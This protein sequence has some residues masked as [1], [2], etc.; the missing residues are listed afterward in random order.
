MSRFFLLFSF[1]LALLLGKADFLL[2]QTSTHRY[3][4]TAHS[5]FSEQVVLIGKAFDA[6]VEITNQGTEPVHSIGYTYEFAGKSSSEWVYRLPFPLSYKGETTRLSLPI[7]AMKKSGSGRLT[8]RIKSVNDQKNEADLSQA[9]AS[10][11]LAVISQSAKRKIVVEDFT[12]T[13]C[14]YCPVAIGAMEIL[15]RDFKDRVIPL[16]VHVHRDVMRS[17][18]YSSVVGTYV[19]GF[20]SVRVNRYKDSYVRLGEDYK[21]GTPYGLLLDIEAEEKV[22]TEAAIKI[23]KATYDPES[24]RVNIET[25]TTFGMSGTDSPYRLAYVLTADGLTGNSYY[26][27]QL[28]NYSG[29]KYYEHLIP[30][31]FKAASRVAIKFDH[32]VV[33]A[34]DVLRGDEATLPANYQEGIAYSHKHA[35]DVSRTESY[36]ISNEHI[37]Q[38]KNKLTAVVMLINTRTRR[39]VNADSAPVVLSTK[40][41]SVRLELGESGMATLA[42]SRVLTVPPG[43]RVSSVLPANHG[44]LRLATIATEGQHLPANAGFLVEGAP[45]T[46]LTFSP[47]PD[48]VATAA[49][50]EG[51]LL[52]PALSPARMRHFNEKL[53]ILAEDAQAGIGFYWQQGTRGEFVSRIEGRAYLALPNVQAAS[54][55]YTFRAGI[56]TGLPWIEAPVHKTSPA[57]YDLSGRRVL[58]P[59]SHGVYLRE[60]RKVLR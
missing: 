6:T 26:W 44:Q 27:Y 22:V 53:Y 11:F 23:S 39:I 19:K 41:K 49:L 34:T 28:N 40:D 31:F 7:P 9:Y 59:S 13:W 60:G 32:T 30:Q 8:L 21:K 48:G 4:V 2:A 52:H 33:R 38:D 15:G 25:N 51:H 56:L 5:S 58:Q 36:E 16:A 14:R 24:N 17:P 37:I 43:A 35:F 29:N 12:A 18:A 54:Q 1:A 57:I 46:S 42:T 55:G 50:P 20:P 47:A 10:G 3:A 45:G